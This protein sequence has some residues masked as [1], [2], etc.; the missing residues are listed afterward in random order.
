MN[1]K[2]EA[3]VEA[4]KALGYEWKKRDYVLFAVVAAELVLPLFTA[5]YPKDK[6]PANG[7]LAARAWLTNPSDAT[8]AAASQAYDAL[9]KSCEVAASAGDDYDDAFNAAAA[10]SYASFGTYAYTGPA[11]IATAD[12]AYRAANAADKS[13]NELIFKKIQRALATELMTTSQTEMKR[14][15]AITTACG[16]RNEAVMWTAKQ[17]EKDVLLTAARIN[18]LL[19]NPRNL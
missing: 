13:T 7:I 8:A 19:P 6:C 2:I 12:Y 18:T 10:A 16:F 15:A 9:E 3:L 4:T 14:V 11:A 5:K 17:L 1:F